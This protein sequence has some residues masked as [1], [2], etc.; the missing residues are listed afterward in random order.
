M[1]P[2]PHIQHAR[3]I[4]RRTHRQVGEQRRLQTGIEQRKPGNEAA[5]FGVQTTD[6]HAI[7]IQAFPVFEGVRGGGVAVFD[8]DAVCGDQAVVIRC[9]VPVELT[10]EWSA[11]ILMALDRGDAA[12]LLSFEISG[13]VRGPAVSVPFFHRRK[14]VLP[15]VLSLA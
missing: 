7:Q 4:Q 1:F 11:A 2:Q 5:G 15:G 6:Q 3:A 14:L 9:R 8:E 13:H 12:I 10:L